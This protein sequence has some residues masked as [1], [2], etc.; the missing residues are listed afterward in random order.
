MNDYQPVSCSLYDHLEVACLQHYRLAIELRDGT[1]LEAE[2]ITTETD[3]QKREFLV[4]RDARGLHRLRLDHL[5]A[6]T[7][8]TDNARF[9]RIEP[10]PRC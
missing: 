9:D 6:I 8:L 1:R 3:E 7:P 2:A 4:V 5:L 10:G